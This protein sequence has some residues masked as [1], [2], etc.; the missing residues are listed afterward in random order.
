MLTGILPNWVDADPLKSRAVDAL[1]LQ[2]VADR[3]ADRLL[4][5][6]SVLTTRA[7]YFTFLCWARQKSGN[8]LNEGEIHRYEIALAIT[9]SRLSEDDPDHRKDCRFVGKRNVESYRSQHSDVVPRDARAVYKVPAWRAYRASMVALGLLDEVAGYRLTD[10]GIEAAKLFQRAVHFKERT[11]KPLRDAAC[12][13]EVSPPE[14]RLLRKLLGLSLPGTLED[15]VSDPKVRRAKFAREIRQFYR[16][17]ILAPDVVLTHHRYRATGYLPEPANTLRSAAVWEYLSLGLNVLFV[18]W[19]RAIEAQL[20][21]VYLRA[22]S[23]RLGVRRPTASLGT[24]ALDLSDPSHAVGG[25]ISCLA[26]ALRRYDRLSADRR[27]L[28]DSEQFEIARRLLAPARPASER[29]RKAL[30]ELLVLHS[31]S[32]GDEAW[33]QCDDLEQLDRARLNRRTKESWQLP[34][35]VSLHSYRMTAFDQI[36]QDVGGL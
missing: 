21:R 28:L 34:K 31:C 2:A 10:Q 6:L 30:T 23:H 9:E 11:P 20:P 1:G 16:N 4:P 3:L 13:S 22:M 33:I 19:A 29:V 15:G 36:L 35:E 27:C 18:G 17:G 14:K 24:V 7:R 12:L 8:R 32:K 25:A 26:E 5:D